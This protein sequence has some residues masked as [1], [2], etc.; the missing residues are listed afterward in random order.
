MDYTLIEAL[1]SGIVPSLIVLLYT[2][3]RDKN[4]DAKEFLKSTLSRIDV[5]EKREY[6]ND[7]HDNIV[8]LRTQMEI[9]IRVLNVDLPPALHRDST[10]EVDQFLE[11]WQKDPY[12]LSDQEILKGKHDLARLKNDSKGMES[13]AYALQIAG[14]DAKLIVMNKKNLVGK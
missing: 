5:L 9:L 12:S 2:M 14:I 13:F 8:V 1:L 3:R 10:P 6:H 7:D 11:K 4:K